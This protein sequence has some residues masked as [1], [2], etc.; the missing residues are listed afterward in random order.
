MSWPAA[1]RGAK[2]RTGGLRADLFP[3]DAELAGFIE[4]CA[5]REVAF[6]CTA[7]LHQAVRHTDPTTGFAHHGF[8]NIVVA[9]CRAVTGGSVV[10][11]IAEADGPRLAAEAREVSDDTTRAARQL[12]ASYGSCSIEEPVAELTALELLPAGG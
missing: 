9:T 2:L 12:F 8:L 7:G 1:D 6:K 5:A 11:A 4:A 3:T 10:E